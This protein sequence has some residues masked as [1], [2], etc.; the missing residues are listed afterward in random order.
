MTENGIPVVLNLNN[1]HCVV[2]GGGPVGM[3][4]AKQFVGA[5]AIVTVIS[6]SLSQVVEG[7][8]FVQAV[9]ESGQLDVYQPFLVVA[10]T[11]DRAVNQ[12]ITEDA[13][14]LGALA[15][16]VDA[17]READVRGVMQRGQDGISFTVQTGSPLLSRLMLDRA[18]ALITS[19]ISQYGQWLYALRE[20][21]KTIIPH[22]PDRAALW[23]DVMGSDVLALLE[24]GQAGEARGLLTE[25][26]GEEL[27]GYLPEE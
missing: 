27:A 17:P 7:A 14:A 26:V 20:P 2:V 12:Q 25:I 8:T 9:Y 18:Q 22:Q 15:M 11:D 5:G 6:R 13:R 10:A 23:R 1:R 21:A 4:K 24:A 3:R 19:A 16:V